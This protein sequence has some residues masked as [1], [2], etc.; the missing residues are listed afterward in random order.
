MNRKQTILCIVL[1]ILF[2]GFL[3]LAIFA[4]RLGLDNNPGW[5]KGRYLLLGFAGSCLL[6]V[7]LNI[8]GGKIE[9]AINSRILHSRKRKLPLWVQRFLNPPLFMTLTLS[10][11]LILLASFSYF[12]FSTRGLLGNIPKGSRYYPMLADAFRSGKLY[13]NVKPSAELQNLENP[14][15]SQQYLTVESLH[16]ASLFK[17]RYYLYW[18]PVPALLTALLPAS[19]VISDTHLTLFFGACLALIGGSFLLFVWRRFFPLISW[20]AVLPGLLILLWGTPLPFAFFG[21]GIYET[22]II[23]GQFFLI[24]GLLFLFIGLSDDKPRFGFLLVTGVCWAMAA[25]S[26]AALTPAIL[27]LTS[28]AFWRAWKISNSNRSIFWYCVVLLGL[29]LAIGAAGLAWYNFARFGSIFETGMCY[30][31]SVTDMR[32][33]CSH[34]FSSSYIPANTFIYLLRPPAINSSFPFVFFEWIKESD[35]P[36]F[37]HLQPFYYFSEPVVGIIFCLPFSLFF[38][39]VTALQIRKSHFKSPS[40]VKYWTGAILL[41]TLLEFIFLLFFFAP[42][43]RYILD[44]SIL[45]TLSAVLGFWM[46]IQ[47]LNKRPLLLIILWVIAFLLLFWTLGVGVFSGISGTSRKFYETNPALFNLLKSW[48]S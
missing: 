32:Q 17:G 27:V 15:D 23:S 24:L 33:V 11:A 26:R 21:S 20:W 1:V 4:E 47:S 35:F 22:A 42:I 16:D 29:P 9:A 39:G 19:L 6:L 44:F 48:F 25:G 3:S 34:I 14:Y 10:F 12:W 30:Q 45:L 37:I 2:L 43:Q 13:L 36:F 18:G 46:L 40:I 38:A 8:W 31:L 28:S 5:G 7:V 41:A